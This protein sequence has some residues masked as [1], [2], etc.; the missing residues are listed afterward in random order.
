[1]NLKGSL[2]VIDISD[3]YEPGIVGWLGIDGRLQDIFVTGSIAY[4]ADQEYGIRLIDVSDP[5]RP[6]LVGGYPTNKEPKNLFVS[7]GY[8]YMAAYGSGLWIFRAGYSISGYIRDSLGNGVSDVTVTLS[9]PDSQATFVT[10]ITGYYEFGG[11]AAGS[12]TV[13]PERPEWSFTPAERSLFVLEEDLA[14]QDFEGATPL[15]EVSGLIHEGGIP[16]EGVVV[17]VT[18]DLEL[19]DTTGADGL[20]AFAL[21][22]AGHYQITPSKQYWLFSPESRLYSDLAE[23]QTG[24]DFTGERVLFSIGGQVVLEEGGGLAGAVV[25]LYGWVGDTQASTYDTTGSDGSYAFSDVPKGSYSVSASKDGY[26]MSP[27][28]GYLLGEIDRDHPDLRFTAD[29]HGFR[30]AGQ[31]LDDRNYGVPGVVLR[32]TGDT[33]KVDT[34]RNAWDAGA[35]Y[36]FSHLDPGRYRVTPSKPGWIFTPEF[37]LFAD[38]DADIYD[39]DFTGTFLSG[40]ARVRGNG[41]QNTWVDVSPPEQGTLRLRI[42]SAEGRLVWSASRAMAPGEAC[43]FEWDHRT[44]HG[45]RVASG[46]YA[47][48]IEGCGLSVSKKLSVVR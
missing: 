23:D 6:L 39:Q 15:L 4:A 42:Y 37:R 40:N 29:W 38:F 48:R 41:S 28:G 12:Y 31:I 17:S 2:N 16:I 14:D 33:T 34:S 46:V 22:H 24:Q 11:L 36:E 47:L 13:R 35:I 25:H 5:S 27:S 1:V 7:D 43:T 20:Y 45:E 44:R 26:G 19:A 9:S 30:I 21:R 32:L 10:G 3:P 18:G 8:L